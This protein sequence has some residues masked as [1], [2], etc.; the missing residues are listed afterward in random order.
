MTAT[1]N[2][3]NHKIT[4]ANRYFKGRN[5]HEEAFTTCRIF[6][7]IAKVF[8][9]EIS[10]NDSFAKVYS[11]EKAFFCPYDFVSSRNYLEKLKPRIYLV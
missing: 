8:S 3:K 10:Q 6:G 2:T 9:P 1:I 7:K 4:T 5:F 11:N